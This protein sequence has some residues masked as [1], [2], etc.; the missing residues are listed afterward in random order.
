MKQNR[1]FQLY[2]LSLQLLL[3]S[4]FICWSGSGHAA[5]TEEVFDNFKDRLLQIRIIDNSTNSKSTLGSGFFIDA[6]GTIVTNYHV[7]SKHIFKPKQYRI[8]YVTSDNK[9]HK[10][11]VINVDVIHDLA[12]LDGDAADTPFLV[13]Q[14]LK[15]DQGTRIYTL[16]N[17]LDLGMTIVE[18]TYN[19]TTDDTMHERILL[20]S[21]L[22]PGMSGGPS[23]LED[24]TI[25]GINVAT[26][27]NN[28][29][30]LVPEKFLRQF[31]KSSHKT[32]TSFLEVIRA[33]LLTNQD[34]Y[35]G[36]LI[37]EGFPTKKLGNYTVPAKLASYINCWGDS[38]DDAGPY[39]VSDNF[40]AT[41]NDIF[42]NQRI[43]TGDIRYTHH[44]LQSKGMNSIRFYNLLTT[45][46]ENP[47]I[48]LSGHKDDFTEF[49]CKTDFV[50]NVN[51]RLRTAFCLRRHK[52]FKDIYDMVL[53]A[54]TI[55]E[56]QKGLITTL[57]LAGVSYDNA[58]TF[59]KKYLE[60]FAWKRP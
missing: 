39:Q 23:I 55:T 2:H 46:F 14:H 28:I 11:E 16:G 26:A 13:M 6:H 22:N 9:V 20:S 57:V 41:K 53:H 49:K 56:N 42:L 27:G 48:S 45:Y 5:A 7:V 8:E 50:E 44:Y 3:L 30:F 4:V 36:A 12:I 32:S 24:G 47:N 35:I 43:S 1:L 59:S 19:G 10:A 21:A 54:G 25:V 17:P 29:G 33:Q 18:G 58:I 51:M 60:A 52:K 34:Q 15:L 37:K 31:V 38:K 40:C